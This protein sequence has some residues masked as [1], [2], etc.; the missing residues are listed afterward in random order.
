MDPSVNASVM[1][2]QLTHTN[3]GHLCSAGSGCHSV[4]RRQRSYAA[5]RLPRSLRSPLRSPLA[6]GLPRCA[7]LVLRRYTGAHANL[8]NVGDTSTPAPRPPALSPQGETRVSQVPGPSSSCVPWSKTPPGATA[9]RPLSVRSPSSSGVAIPWT[10]GSQIHF[11]AAPPTAHTL[12]CLRI[13]E[14]VT[15]SGARLATG[16]GGLTLGQ[17]GFAPAG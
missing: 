1:S 13:A 2:P 6:N 9:P 3:T 10:P 12:A 15:V 8:C 17:A 16:P 14:S 7:G 11:V 5:L 4:P